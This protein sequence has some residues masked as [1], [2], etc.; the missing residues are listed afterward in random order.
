MDV[1]DVRGQLHAPAALH[2]GK[3][4]VPIVEEAAWPPA[5]VWT[6]AENFASTGI[7]LN[8]RIYSIILATCLGLKGHHQVAN[9]NKIIYVHRLC[10]IEIFKP[11]SLHCDVGAY[12]MRRTALGIQFVQLCSWVKVKV[13]GKVHLRTGHEGPER[14]QSYNSTLSLISAL[15]DSVPGPSSH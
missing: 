9:K 1:K 12:G 15:D 8:L 6:G 2:S 7:F 4:P 10:G 3:D 13:K 11:Q 14:E 5:P